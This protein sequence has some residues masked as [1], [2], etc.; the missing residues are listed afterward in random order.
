MAMKNISR[1]NLTN[2]KYRQ[3]NVICYKFNNLGYITKFYRRRNVNMNMRHSIERKSM[4]N[5]GKGKEK[6]D[7]YEVRQQMNKTW[8]RKGDIN[9]NVESTPKYGM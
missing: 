9:D 4:K 3:S 8:V 7:V 2:Y 1:G 6:V 5:N